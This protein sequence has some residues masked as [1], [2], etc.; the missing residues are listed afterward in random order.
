MNLKDLKIGNQLIMAFACI[1]ILVIILGIVSYRQTNKLQYQTEQ[2]FNHPFQVQA[3]IADL[4]KNILSI[5]RDMKDLFIAIDEKELS[6]SFNEIEIMNAEAAA[7]FDLLYNHYLGDKADIDSLRSAYVVWNSMREET[8]RILRNGGIQEAANRTKSSGIAGMQV[9]KVLDHVD[10]IDR[11][12]LNKADS[13]HQESVLL[14]YTLNKRLIIL[15]AIILCASMMIYLLLIRY[16]RNPVLTIK[17]AASKFMN[18]QY[19][20]RS[21]YRSLNEFG[22]LAETFDTLAGN[23]QKNME[24]NRITSAISELMIR[25]DDARKFFRS[26]LLFLSE[27]CN[28]QMAAVF[29][30]EKDEKNY[31]H[32]ESIGLTDDARPS[33]DATGFEGEFGIAL[34]SG[35]IHH[36]SNIAEDTRFTFQTV[37]GSFVPHEIITIPILIDD[38]IMAVVSLASIGKFNDHTFQVIDNIYDTLCARVGGI[39]AY[40]QIKEIS[41]VLEAKNRELEAQKAKL[42][43]QSSELQEQNTELEMQKKQL[44]EANRLKTNFLSNM[45]HEL[46]TP[47]NSVIALSGVLN[48]RLKGQIA[49]EEYSY[50]DVIERNGRHL[51]TLI[52]DILDI[53]RIEAGREEVNIENF[54]M[55]SLLNE[56]VLMLKPQADQ[57]GIILDYQSKNEDLMLRSDMAKCRHIMQNLVGNAIKFTDR[58]SVQ[59]YAEQDTESVA[60]RI[61]DTG[62]GIEEKHLAHIFDEFRQADGSTSR[63]FG[64]TGLGLAIARKYAGLLGGEIRVKSTPGKGSEFSLILPLRQPGGIAEKTSRSRISSGSSSGFEDDRKKALKEKTILIVEDS[65]AAIIQMKDILSDSGCRIME[66]SGGKQAIRLIQ[67]DIPDAIILD[68]MMPEV[69]GFEFLRALRAD[70]ATINT[71]V[72]ILTAKHVSKEELSFLQGNNIHQLIQKGDINRAGLLNAVIS[73]LSLPHTHPSTLTEGFPAGKKPL[74]LIV[75]DNP[76]NLITAR[77]ILSEMFELIEAVNGVQGVEMAINHRPQLVLMDIALPEMDGIEAFKAIRNDPRTLNIPIVAL[78]AS[79]MTSDRETILAYGF[80]AYIAKPIDAENLFKTIKVVL[81]GK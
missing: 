2:L 3:A 65:E 27:Y 80:D 45:S 51:L 33:F 55:E 5:H 67:D 25:E 7:N 49:E 53:S 60:I 79:A 56:I 23:V 17:E 47:L 52:N 28:A 39:L 46:R 70:P 1:L 73:L 69:D 43:F 61:K 34:E 36:I 30:L 58:G 62:I 20:A 77:A 78:T 48:R 31:V 57:K 12:S 32:F 35:K 75:E 26:I 6:L 59:I 54:S 15:L 42:S 16:I 76:D 72:L 13:M 9:K 81:Y 10:V 11:Y 71:P 29:L 74:V 68:L 21:G 14:N 8:I 19:D 37:S 63:R 18:G 40:R 41:E 4:R 38:K 64:G 66:A 50:L 24:L 44:N 22:L